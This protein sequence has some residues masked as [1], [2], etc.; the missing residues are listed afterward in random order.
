MACRAA[1]L[2]ALLARET[3]AQANCGSFTCPTGFEGRLQAPSSIT[4]ANNVCTTDICCTQ[5]QCSTSDSSAAILVN[6]AN[7]L[8]PTLSSCNTVGSAGCALTC[9]SGFGNG[10]PVLSCVSSG[11]G[12]VWQV[13]GS[14]ATLVCPSTYPCTS[15]QMVCG[16][17]VSSCNTFFTSPC[18]AA[19]GF[20]CKPGYSGSATLTCGADGAWTTSGTCTEAACTNWA[21]PVGVEAGLTDP[22]TISGGVVPQL[23]PVTSPTACR[24]R[25]KSGYIT[26]GSGVLSCLITGSTAAFSTT[27]NCTEQVCGPYTLPTGVAA[28]ASSG[29]TVVDGV[30]PGGTLTA[31]T[32]P[33]C[34]IECAAG[35]NTDTEYPTASPTT[36][37]PSA[38]PTKAPTISP[39]GSPTRAPTRSPTHAPTTATNWPSNPPTKVPTASP[40]SAPTWSPTASPTRKPSTSPTGSPTMSPTVIKQLTCNAGSLTPTAALRCVPFACSTLSVTYVLDSSGAQSA[41]VAFPPNP[42]YSGALVEVSYTASTAWVKPTNAGYTCNVTHGQAVCLSDGAAAEIN[43]MLCTPKVCEDVTT[44]TGKAFFAGANAVAPTAQSDVASCDTVPETAGCSVTCAQGYAAGTACTTKLL[45]SDPTPNDASPGGVGAWALETP[46]TPIACSVADLLIST[47]NPYNLR[48]LTQADLIGCDEVRESGTPCTAR[49]ADGYAS[50][51]TGRGPQIVCKQTSCAGVWSVTEHCVAMCAPPSVPSGATLLS[52]TASSCTATACTGDDIATQHATVTRAT[53]AV[54]PTAAGT[55]TAT[56]TGWFLHPQAQSTRCNAPSGTFPADPATDCTVQQCCRISCGMYTACGTGFTTKATPAAH[57]CAG[58]LLSDCSDALCC[59]QV[60]CNTVNAPTSTQATVNCNSATAHG[61]E[62]LVTADAGYVCS[63]KVTCTAGTAPSYLTTP[64]AGATTLC[65]IAQCPENSGSP[66]SCNCNAGYAG[67]AQWSGTQWTHSCIPEQCART[68]VANS[69][70]FSGSLS[71]SGTTGT[72]VAVVCLTG[73]SLSSATG[74]TTCRGATLQF[75]VVT[76]DAQNCTPRQFPNSQYAATG[77]VVGKTGESRTVTCDKGYVGTGTGCPSACT[78]TCDG[79]TFSAVE[80]TAAECPLN[81]GPKGTCACNAGYAVAASGSPTWNTALGR[82]THVC[83][84][85]CGTYTCQQAGLTGL[86]PPDSF[87]CPNTSASSCA[88]SLCCRGAMVVPTTGLVTTEGGGQATFTVALVSRPKAAVSVQYTSSDTTEGRVS[89][90][91]L[92]F[93]SNNWNVL[94]T[95]TVV[96]QDDAVADGDQT[97]YVRSSLSISTDSNYNG[98]SFPQVTLT[99]T[100]DDTSG[101]LVSPISGLVTTEA[102]GSDTFTVVLRSEPTSD[103]TI[104][105]GIPANQASEGTLSATSLLFT[106]GNWNTAQTVTVTGVADNVDDGN[107]A[108]VIDLGPTTSSDKAYDQVSP[109]DVQV[110]NMDDDTTG[111]IVTPTSGL[112]TTEGGGQATFT[113]RL[114]SRPTQTVSIPLRSSNTAEGAVSPTVV[115]IAPAAWQTAQTVTVTGVNDNIDDDDIAYTIILDAASSSDGNY[116]GLDPNDVSVVNID[117]DSRGATVTP[118]S[119]LVT[120]ELGRSTRFIMVLDTQPTATVMFTFTGDATEGVL[121]PSNVYFSAA[122]YS[123]QQTVTVTGLNDNI[124]DGPI[125]YTILGRASS[126]DAKY[127]GYSAPAITVTNEDDDV[128]GI[129]V[130]PT[131]GLVTTEKGGRANFTMRLTSEPVAGVTIALSTDPSEGALTPTLLSFNS[132]N[133]DCARRRR[134]PSRFHVVLKALHLHE[135]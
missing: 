19:S 104:P 117:D 12:G 103:V 57:A 71:L 35:Y 130:S 34:G 66:P 127:N 48:T 29:C 36:L 76:C 93:D 86:Q 74:T 17:D 132:A 1:L 98:R 77:S 43:G 83:L 112:Q 40:T 50:G 27:L 6:N 114:N 128:A 23:N 42:I 125:T 15:P 91:T 110:T 49:C 124:A 25:C 60:L 82:W 129:K 95:V 59:D 135:G 38:S 21:V 53:C 90:S 105:V 20:S 80:C 123:T 51:A 133:G 44:A 64:A 47:T 111:I 9:K 99:N 5:S 55:G 58:P 2:A 94:Q 96:G 87:L 67:T 11:S 113:I 119:G 120:T 18:P 100:D 24:L 32:A 92:V 7:S 52:N 13:S 10:S 106:T 28:T 14:C 31:V 61:A 109:S 131:A 39:T 101:V 108:Y 46:C 26:T 81:S 118:T 8:L 62:C 16:L 72:T 121:S 89:V 68:S 4:C 97:Y 69:R 134:A 115:Q 70:D 116:N 126:A 65:T 22:C 78:T 63:G 54:L 88:D 73:Y 85:T 37:A 107:V 79:S 75:D 122:N 45:C 30:V 84:A 3:R 56:P 102:G 33:S 41:S